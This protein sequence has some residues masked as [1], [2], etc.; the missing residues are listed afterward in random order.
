MQLRVQLGARRA[1]D[2][3]AGRWTER[4]AHAELDVERTWIARVLW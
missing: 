2:C 1:R 3:S 4:V